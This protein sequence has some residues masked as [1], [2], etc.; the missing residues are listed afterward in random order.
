MSTLGRLPAEVLSRALGDAIGGRRIRAG[1][2][3]TFTFDPAFFELHVLPLLFDQPFSQVEKVRRIQLEDALRSVDHLA[4]YYD[5]GG[6]SQDAA[7]AQL[8]YR[9][10]DVRRP[11]GVFHPKLVLLLVDEPMDEAEGDGA[12]V[13]PYQSLVVGVL[14]A[15]LTRAGWWENVECAHFEEVRDRDLDGTRTSF[16]NDL[17]NLIRQIRAGT[18]EDQEHA[19]LDRIHEFLRD[20]APTGRF[21]HAST[22][23]EW[24][25]RLFFG[26]GR[27]SLAQWLGKLR[28]ARHEWNLEVVSPY[29]DRDGA[30]PLAD[31]AEALG[32]RE[33]RVFLPREADGQACVTSQVYEAVAK[34]ARWSRLPGDLTARGRG[35]RAER[36]PPRN[37]HAKLYRLWHRDGRDVLVLGSTNLTHAGMS[38]AGAGNLE[39]NLL[40]DI[41]RAG[42]PRRWWL[43]PLER[44]AERFADELPEET[45]GLE[46]ASFDVS[47]CFDWGR[48]SLS[49]RLEDQADSF[50]VCQPSGP[51]LFRVERPLSA[52]WVECDEQAAMRVGELLRSTSFLL[53]RDSEREW[54]VLVREENMGHRPSLLLDLTPEEILEYWSLLTPEQRAAFVEF[55]AGGSLDGLRVGRR[56]R[57]VSRDTMFDRFAGIYHAFGCLRRHIEKAFQEDRESEAEARLLGAKYDSLPALLQKTLDQKDGDPIARYVTFLCAKQLRDSMER[58]YPSFFRSRRIQ[59]ARLA[60]ILDQVAELRAAVPLGQD[61]D[62]FLDWYE[63]MFL[64]EVAPGGARR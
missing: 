30:G 3:T 28:L 38:H 42:Y 40:V 1:V 20:R 37:V 13:A 56:D 9:R 43:E 58:R 19:A 49:Y 14:S 64:H 61:G 27:Q 5:R 45:D 31:L 51:R 26:Q 33:I 41:S 48:R 63:A 39:A 4:V 55:H 8:D 23:G 12:N 54:R 6:L 11:T 15:N 57:L 36:L 53:I 2:F 59:A 24:Y 21:E 35:E 10:I 52:K 50:D 18:P 62:D 32:P 47:F 7:P 17:L 34:L 22:R 25:T 60:E 46:H 29:F 16:R 44:E